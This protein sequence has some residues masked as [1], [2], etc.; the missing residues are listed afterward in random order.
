MKKIL[1]NK[2]GI[3]ISP[4]S[5]AVAIVLLLIVMV[6]LLFIFGK[7]SNNFFTFITDIFKQTKGEKCVSP[8]LQ[9]YCNECP[10][11]DYAKKDVINPPK[12][13]WSDCNGECIECV[14]NKI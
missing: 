10:S 1:Y 13:G 6:I 12:D 7:S 8:F 9:R 2:K 5:L 4:M 14:Y 11:G 3:E